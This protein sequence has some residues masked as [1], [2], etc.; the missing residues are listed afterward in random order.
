MIT[1]V[2]ICA[3]P[4]FVIGSP[5]S[6]TSVLAWGLSHHPDFW[7]SHETEFLI[8]LFSQGRAEGAYDA[9]VSRSTTWLRHHNVG[10][11]EF[12]TYL[13][14]GVNALITSRAEG[15]RWIDQTPG[16]TMLA[17][18][19]ADLFPTARFLHIV[20]DGR[21]VVHSMKSFHRTLGQELVEAESLP[22]WAR[23]FE[24]GVRQWRQYVETANAFCER[25]PDRTLT[26]AHEELSSEPEEAFRRVFAF[27]GA[28]E[29]SG[30]ARFVRSHRV[31]SS[32][33]TSDWAENTGNGVGAVEA[34]ASWSEAE[35]RVFAAEAN[36]LM[37][38]LGFTA[39]GELGHEGEP[40][41]RASADFA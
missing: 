7:T 17:A 19:L 39:P 33:A 29:T 1:H 16:Y 28:D 34:A 41:A 9:G 15:R 2:K 36:E 37:V 10:R 14:A 38:R 26:I 11:G 4:V 24:D 6:G 31:N 25:H 8:E 5:R 18:S 23:S 40:A 32:F 30:P 27:L 21:S 20:R 22:T 3:D 13:G 35:R 12:L